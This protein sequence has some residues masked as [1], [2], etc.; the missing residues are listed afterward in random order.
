MSDV[1]DHLTEAHNILTLLGMPPAQQNE[2][3][4]LCLLALLNLTPDKDW[5]Q[6]ETPLIGITPIMD[7][8]R[9]HY[10]KE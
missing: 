10:G 9:R 1:D 3:S 4:A 5:S 7:W 8:V 2:R 6:A